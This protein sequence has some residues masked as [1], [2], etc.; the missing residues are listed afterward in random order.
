MRA[1]FKCLLGTDRHGA[2]INFLSKKPVPVFDHPFSKE[3]FPDV[4]SEPPQL[5]SVSFPHVLP[6]VTRE[7]RPAPPSALPLLRK[8][9]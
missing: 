8:K 9:K 5:S 7:Q 4:R 6:S 2:G 3:V 1:L